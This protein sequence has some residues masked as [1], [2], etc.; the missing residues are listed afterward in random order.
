MLP[1]VD[2]AIHSP[3]DPLLHIEF[4]RHFTHA[5]AFIP[6]GGVV[7]ALPWMLW[8][9]LRAHG[10]LFLLAA[11]LGYA[12]HG[13]LDASTTYGTLLLWPFSNQRF[14]F[15]WISIVD[16]VFTLV[17]LVG[18]VVAWRGRGGRRAAVIALVAGVG[19]LA[20]GAWQ[21][22]RAIDVQRRIAHSRGHSPARATVFPGFANQLVW[23]SLY[24]TEG[25]L[26]MDRIRVPWIGAPTWS[27]GT[28]VARVDERDLHEVE[29]TSTR[30]HRD[31]E[32]FAWFADGW[33]ARS[34]VDPSVIGDA[35]YSLSTERFE[36]V[37]GIRFTPR[38]QPPIEW[39]DY[40]RGRRIDLRVW[41]DEV[42]GRDPQFR[43]LPPRAAVTDPR[44]QP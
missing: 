42:R 14:A 27:P 9:A 26:V 13:L 8:P 24:E 5:L 33:V 21:R 40:S 6:I 16:P 1:D 29:G 22:D 11:T 4:H 2:R 20:L 23:R 25:T 30:L 41:R 34:A 37:W 17:L 15:N 18:L 10:R 3:N 38:Q 28:A 35:R 7:A 44:Q 12:T 31:F 36:P 43:A 19:Y 32:R 39:V